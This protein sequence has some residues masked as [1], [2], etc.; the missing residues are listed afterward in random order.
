MDDPERTVGGSDEDVNTSS[1]EPPPYE[2]QEV[3]PEELGGQ[4]V[5][6]DRPLDRARKAF[7][8]W[9]KGLSVN[10]QRSTIGI[11]VVLLVAA[12]NGFGANED[13]TVTDSADSAPTETVA[14]LDFSDC[15][16]NELDVELCALDYEPTDS[17]ET[18]EACFDD[19]IDRAFCEEYFV[20]ATAATLPP[21]TV[22]IPPP[23]A[24]AASNCNPNYSGCV[25][26]A[27][28]VDCA[29]G[30]GNGPAYTGPVQVTG[31]DVYDLDADGDGLACE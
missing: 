18:F 15:Y 25:P 16:L 1:R 5:A 22:F 3:R 9:W 21:T 31:V 7:V 30:S 29:G 17:Y 11:A 10:A 4:Y 23:P 14:Y 27:S 13:E 8:S 19:T 12:I 20:P 24:P 26:N 2:L 6:P 28:D